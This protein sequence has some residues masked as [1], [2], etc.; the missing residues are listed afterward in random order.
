MS[1][2]KTIYGVLV[3][4]SIVDAYHRH[5]VVIDVIH[6]G[7][8][9]D[10]IDIQIGGD[11]DYKVYVTTRVMFYDGYAECKVVYHHEFKPSYIISFEFTTYEEF[12]SSYDKIIDDIFDGKTI[13]DEF[14]GWYDE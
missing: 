14:K 5:H 12:L 2:I 8:P 10:D 7:M 4:N 6:S 13:G 1:E 11:R 9:Y 3:R